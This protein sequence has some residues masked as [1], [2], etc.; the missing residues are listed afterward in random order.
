MKKDK[1][2]AVVENEEEPEL[3]VWDLPHLEADPPGLSRLRRR[4]PE[5]EAN[6]FDMHR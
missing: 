6:Y 3:T 4:M 5:F 1:D 2:E